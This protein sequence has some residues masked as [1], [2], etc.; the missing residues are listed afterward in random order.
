MGSEDKTKQNKTCTYNPPKVHMLKLAVQFFSI[1][2]FD[3]V[4]L[5]KLIPQQ[6]INYPPLQPY[7]PT[8]LTPSI[9][10]VAHLRRSQESFSTL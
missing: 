7:H 6:Y 2:Y 10:Y 4:L 5:Q 3:S 8:I 1:L 9:K